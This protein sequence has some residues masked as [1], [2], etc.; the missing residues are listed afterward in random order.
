[1]I[2]Y[3]IRHKDSAYYVDT[4]AELNTW[5]VTGL[6]MG[7]LAYVIEEKKMMVLN[8]AGEWKEMKYDYL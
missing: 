1:M 5:D 2:S 8:S 4:E 7:T 6:P 3:V